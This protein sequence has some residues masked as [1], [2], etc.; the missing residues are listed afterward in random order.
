MG[1]YQNTVFKY[2]ETF[3]PVGSRYGDG[4]RPARQYHAALPVAQ[5]SSITIVNNSDGTTF[6]FT[7]DGIAFSLADT[8]GN[9]AAVAAE[10]ADLVNEHP[11]A[12]QIARA[13]DQGG[14]VL[15][16]TA[17]SP[18]T[19]FTAT[20]TSAGGTGTLTVATVTANNAGVSLSPG[21]PVFMAAANTDPGLI[22]LPS[23]NTDVFMG[24]VQFRHEDAEL[25]STPTGFS[26]PPGT[27][28]P[29][30]PNGAH[31]VTVETA[32]LPGDNVFVRFQ[33]GTIGAWRNDNAGGDAVQITGARFLSNS[34][35][36]NKAI[37]TYEVA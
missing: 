6:S 10:F 24:V 27:H 8:F 17:R 2:A 12:S 1:I 11:L 13:E 26:Y 15:H 35:A 20:D 37:V 3:G 9:A 36:G 22:Q 25:E 16:L 21:Q 14:G 32:V 7:L 5:V 30:D 34:A 4:H 18:G 28:V 19:A 31:V 29:V 23:A 33:N